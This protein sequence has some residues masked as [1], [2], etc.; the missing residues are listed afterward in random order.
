MNLN[1]FTWLII[2]DII[3]VEEID[4]IAVVTDDLSAFD[5]DDDDD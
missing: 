1:V 4:V 2:N 5:G 3:F